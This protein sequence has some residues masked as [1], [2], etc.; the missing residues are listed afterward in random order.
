MTE[1]LTNPKDAIGS[2][3]LPLN[4]IPDTA[5]VHMS[6]AF[7]EGALKYGTSNWRIAGVR[8][9][10]YISAYERH[11]KK[12]K[13]GQSADPKT[14]IHHLGSA[15]ACLAILLDA[16]LAGK[17]NDDRPPSVPLEKLIDDSEETVRHLMDLF[18]DHNPR[19]YTIADTEHPDAD[20]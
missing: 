11:T 17:L 14:R 4:L 12:W 15:M 6:L 1:K 3:K 20:L 13:N 7:L 2:T 16:E 10:I 19:H 8:A 18:K 9:S 5:L